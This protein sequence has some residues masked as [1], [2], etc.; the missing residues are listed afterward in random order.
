MPQYE[1]NVWKEVELISKEVTYFEDDKGCANYI[2]NKYHVP[3]SWTH[4]VTELRWRPQRGIRVTWGKLPEYSYKPKKMLTY[5]DKELQRRL[6]E[7][8]TPKTIK[9]FKQD[10][11]KDMIREDFY[12]NP[13]AKGYEDHK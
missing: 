9:E 8:I 10:Q 5:E 2:N 12:S 4:A 6:D 11:F 13:D 7:S 3:G 1:I